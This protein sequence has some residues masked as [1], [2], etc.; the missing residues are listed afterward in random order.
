MRWNWV[1]RYGRPGPVQTEIELFGVR[2]RANRH[3]SGRVDGVIRP[4]ATRILANAAGKARIPHITGTL[5]TAT[6]EDVVELAGP[7][8]WFQLYGL[9]AD[10]HAVTFDLIKR[11]RAAGARI[12]AGTLD[13]PVRSKRPRDLRNGLVVPFRP[14]PKT[15]WKWHCRRHGYLR[16][17]QPA[18]RHFV[19]WSAMSKSRQRWRTRPVLCRAGS[20]AHFRGMS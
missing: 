11:A 12:I 18:R 6:I 13:T 20:R 3:F 16:S 8:A 19:I 9:P 2:C 17:P 1:P 5:G 7:Y 14:T 4:G 10:D 15:I